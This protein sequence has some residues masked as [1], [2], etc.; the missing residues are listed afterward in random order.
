MRYPINE[1]FET[2]QGEGS[3]TGTAAIFVRLQGCPVGCPWCDTRHTWDTKPEDET[4]LASVM[5]K[6][7]DS[8]AWAWATAA[9]LLTAFTQRGFRA[10]HVVITGG[11][12]AMFDLQE[13]C[14]VLHQGGYRTQIETSGTFAIQAPAE[15]FVTLSPKVG[16][17][18]GYE[19]LDSALLRADE[20]KHPVARQRDIDEL[21]QLLKRLPAYAETPIWL[22]PVSQGK[23]ATQLCIDTCIARN[24]RL[25]VQLHK[26]LGIE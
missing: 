11:E 12:P 8:P 10:R 4:E 19:V 7:G 25:S 24:W 1:V 18:G 21:D 15:T 20:I 16:M 2:L 26:Y 3:F 5:A 6:R 23:R 9:S 13:L 14:T 22:Q 17:K